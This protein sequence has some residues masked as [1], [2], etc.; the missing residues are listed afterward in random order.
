MLDDAGDAV[1]SAPHSRLWL[2]TTGAS[3]ELWVAWLA[4]VVV[5]GVVVVVVVVRYEVVR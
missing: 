5:V 1:R 2:R 3:R 4:L